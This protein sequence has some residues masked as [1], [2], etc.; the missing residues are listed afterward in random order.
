VIHIMERIVIAGGRPLKG[1][2][3]VTGAKNAALPILCATLLTEEPCTIRGLPG[4]TDIDVMSEILR[5]LGA[6]VSVAG[7]AITVQA[8]SL[9]SQAVP[10]HLMREMRSSIIV[11]GALLTRFGRV[12]VSQPGGCAIGSRPIDLHLK[13]LKDLGAELVERHGYIQATCDRLQGTSIHLDYPSV[14]ATEN[15]MMAATLAQGQ[16]TITNAAKEPEIVDLQNFLNVLGANVK[17]AGTAT[18]RIEGVEKLGG[19]DYTIIPDRIVAGTYVLAGAATHGQVRVENVIPEHL[20]SL[21]A[22]LREIGI[23]VTAGD[24]FIEIDAAGPFRAIESVRTLPYPGFPTDLQAPMMALLCLAEGTSIVTET[25]F[26]SRFK[27][28]DELRRMG[29]NIK[30]HERS[31][32]IKGVSNLTG[33]T[34][35]AT[36]LRAGAALVIAGLVA[37]GITVIED[38]RHIYRGYDRLEE[39]LR[40]LGARIEGIGR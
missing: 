27:H 3:R 20:E 30:V 24:D 7:D 33:A 13:G 12:R 16:T 14:G 23:G 26:E 36:D 11:M 34:V 40:A 19:A 39:N 37:D 29:A 6:E 22:K 31:A 1:S 5:S 18:I 8:N 32:V 38:V 4:L 9:T 15:L 35:C 10:D 25:V 28:V 21:L 17:G 2:V